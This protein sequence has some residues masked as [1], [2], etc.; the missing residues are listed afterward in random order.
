MTSQLKEFFPVLHLENKMSTQTY[1]QICQISYVHKHF[2]P[3]EKN[4]DSKDN[5]I[6][7]MLCRKNS[8][9]CVLHHFDPRFGAWA[10]YNTAS[11]YRNH[12]NFVVISIFMPQCIKTAF[13]A[14]FFPKV[15]NFK[16]CTI[17]C[18]LAKMDETIPKNEI[19]K[20]YKNND[21]IIINTLF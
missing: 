7:F 18:P 3:T 12:R 21:I 4:K 17:F 13:N 16:I 10:R 11:H 5:F 6:G 8:Y 14:P 19:C 1:S 2:L 9:G 15:P 20:L